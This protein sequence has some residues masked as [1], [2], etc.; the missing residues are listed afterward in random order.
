MMGHLAKETGGHVSGQIE[1]KSRSSEEVVLHIRG[2]LT[3]GTLKAG[4]KLPPE[5]ELVNLLGI[6]RPAVREGLRLLE[7]SGLVEQ[8]LGR[9]GGTFVGNGSMLFISRTMKDLMLLQQVTIRQMT[10]A[11]L[12]IQNIVVN[13]ACERA[14]QGDLEDLERN[15][16]DAQAAFERGELPLQTELNIEFHNMLARATHN[17]I[18]VMNVHTITDVLRNF[19]V[20][21]GPDRSGDSFKMR[22]RLLSALKARDKAESRRAVTAI[23][24]R[25]ERFLAKSPS[26]NRASKTTSQ[27]RTASQQKSRAKR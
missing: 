15:I 26:P 5:R 27:G 17:P 12:W 6:G 14:T 21:V 9:T 13:V 11:R 16:D 10:E 23:L 22:R 25:A 4:D 7:A 3:A 2:Q 8:R 1:S 20:R 19:S 18:L 24:R